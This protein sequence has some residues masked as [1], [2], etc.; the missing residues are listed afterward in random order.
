MATNLQ[1]FVCQIHALFPERGL[2]V[3]VC[4]GGGAVDLSHRYQKTGVGGLRVCRAV[5]SCLRHA[6]AFR[7]AGGTLG[8]TQPFGGAHA[9]P[10]RERTSPEPCWLCSVRV[11]GE[12]AAGTQHLPC[13]VGPKAG[14][15]LQAA[16]RPPGLT[17]PVGTH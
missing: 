11:S 1:I 13:A 7:G 4:V 8:F 6:L 9:T 15:L 5:P 17:V 14:V 12:S 3:R 2:V 10:R 16:V